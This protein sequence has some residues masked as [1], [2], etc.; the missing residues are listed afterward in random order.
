M[1][2]AFELIV[3]Q[4][5]DPHAQWSLGTFGAIAEFMRDPDEPADI[6]RDET[7]MSVV[8]PRGGIRLVARPSLRPIA[9]ETITTQAWSQRVAFCLPAA[10]S[11]MNRRA[12]L[13]ELGSDTD[14]L[15][16]QDRD[17]I[18][19]DLGLGAA[20]V[21]CCI[22]SADA[23]LIAG[24][25]AH[26]GRSLFEPGN[27]AMGLIL[28]HS[29]PRVFVTRAGRAEVYQSIP[30]PGGKAPEGPH[31]HVLPKLLAHERTHAATEPIPRGFVSCAH[32]YPA[33][34]LRDGYGRARPF[35]TLR[36][37]AFQRLL[38]RYGDIEHVRLKRNVTKAINAG[39]GPEAIA[40]P[41]DRFAQASIRVALRQLKA[42]E[43][44][45]PALTAW[46]AAH[47]V[48]AA[49]EETEEQGR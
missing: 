38:S 47:D 14:A 40:M 17:A 42:S 24:L 11:A 16:P 31:T 7:W 15:R 22:R 26:A 41:K 18:R 19:F 32:L 12:A 49:N 21:D 20:Q 10:E 34:P 33:H 37:T 44:S 45:S 35:D 48:G 46:F 4:L 1:A 13:T 5:A 43:G 36:Y 8:T 2:S 25:R 9:F 27:P 6:S 3:D 30:A 28:R 39:A 23:E 29:P